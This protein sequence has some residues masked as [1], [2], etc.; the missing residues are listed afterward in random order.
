VRG[1]AQRVACDGQFTVYMQQQTQEALMGVDLC[2][3]SAHRVYCIGLFDELLLLV[4]NAHSKS[5][6]SSLDIALDQQHLG[7]AQ[8]RVVCSEGSERR[9][10]QY[11]V[12]LPWARGG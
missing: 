6:R 2:G 8:A 10:S 11:V 3:R 9:T 4:N 12:G 1:I 5:G 7:V